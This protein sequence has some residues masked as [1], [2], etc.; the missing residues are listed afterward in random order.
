MTSMAPWITEG[1]KVNGLHEVRDRDR[2]SKWLRSDGK[3]LGN[4]SKL[5]WCG[6][7]VDT[8]INLALPDEP[9]PGNLGKNPYWALNWN[10]LGVKVAPCLY[11]VVTF[12]R[13]GG[14]HVG[15]LMGEDATHYYVF[16][17]NQGDT[18]S[19]VRIEKKR[20][21]AIRWPST[22][23]H[24]PRRPLPLLRADGTPVSRNEA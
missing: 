17:G 21:K 19:I 16:G 2:L 9:R 12:Q 8:C 14:G 15:F 7:F 13:Q 3:F 18:V 22:A 23:L 4:P 6:D 10:L 1:M 24:L 11:A 20:M 5:P